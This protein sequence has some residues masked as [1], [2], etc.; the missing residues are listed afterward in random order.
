MKISS[1]ETIPLRIPFTHGGPPPAFAG[2]PRTTMDTLLIRI[3]SD[4][5]MVGWGDGFGALIWPATRLVVQEFVAPLL[6]GAE[7]GDPAAM[8]QRLQVT[9]H[10]LGRGG[11]TMF[12]LSGV[13]IALWDLAA[14]AQGK[15]LHALLG[16]ARRQ[17]VEAYASLLRYGDPALVAAG[18]E[19]ALAA[20]YRQVKLHEIRHD[21]I[22]AARRAAGPE[23][24]IMVDVNCA[25]RGDEAVENAR[26]IAAIAPLWVEEPAWPP[27]DHATLAR[28]RREAGVA[29]AAGETSVCAPDLAQMVAAGAVDF[30]QPSVTRIGGITGFL[31]AAAAAAQHGVRL[32]PHSAYFGPGFAATLHLLAAAERETVIERF[33]VDLEATP[34]A[35]QLDVIGG[36]VAVPQGPGLGVEPEPDLIARFRA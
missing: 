24:P 14:K 34:F 36:R 25:W 10:N 32:A 11:P 9:L 20:G 6:I 4:T 19:R 22:G 35:G 17:G 30:A 7:L 16:G 33:F 5:G 23:V 8:S 28:V 12:A 29:V 1:I 13:D 26:R 31:E 21:A 3:E 18:V 2:R 15:P 27:E